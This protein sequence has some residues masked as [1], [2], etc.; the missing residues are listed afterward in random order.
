[1][2]KCGCST[3]DVKCRLG[4]VKVWIPICDNHFLEDFLSQIKNNIETSHIDQTGRADTSYKIP[5]D[6]SRNMQYLFQTK[7]LE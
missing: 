6:V 3:F 2:H 5:G 4:W 7:Y 1:M